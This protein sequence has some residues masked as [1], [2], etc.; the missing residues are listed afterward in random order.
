MFEQ[1]EDSLNKSM[2][3]SCKN[4][5]N[6]RDFRQLFEQK[7]SSRKFFLDHRKSSG[8]ETLNSTNTHHESNHTFSTAKN[9]ALERIKRNRSELINYYYN[10]KTKEQEK[11]EPSFNFN[12]NKII[13]EFSTQKKI[14]MPIYRSLNRRNAFLTHPR[15][16]PEK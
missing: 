6:E 2:N 13:S 4:R 3:D 12:S 1:N 8:W 11:K 10:M 5:S 7:R 9:D 16:Q 15:T 14:K